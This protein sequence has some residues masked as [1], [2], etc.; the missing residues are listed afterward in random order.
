M[1]DPR[2]LLRTS[3]F[4][5]AV[6]YLL[7][8]WSSTAL[9]MGITWRITLRLV[10]EHVSETIDTEAEGLADTY[11]ARGLTGLVRVIEGRVATP[12]NAT[13]YL[14]ASP[15]FEPL[16]G[17]LS[18]W[19]VAPR[20][21]EGW[22]S[23]MLEDSRLPDSG[24]I[25]AKARSFLLAGGFHL[26]VGRDIREGDIFARRLAEGMAWALGISVALGLVGAVLLA[27]RALKRV[28]KISRTASR[29]V[30]GDLSARMPQNGSGDELDRLV[31]AVNVMLDRLEALMQGL[32]RLSHNIA[33]ELK[34]PLSRLSNRVEEA[35]R[36]ETDD[37]ATLR[38]ALEGVSAEAAQM[39]DLFR[40]LL[41]IAEAEAGLLRTTGSVDLRQLL[42]DLVELY[43]PAAE[44]EGLML[45]AALGDGPVVVEGHAQLLSRAFANLLD[46]ALKYT[47]EGGLVLV[48][49]EKL[50]EGWQVSVSDTGPGV[51][52]ADRTRVVEPFERGEHPDEISGTG[53]G[54]ALVRAVAR[55]HRAEF[56]LTDGDGTGTSPGLKAAIT[57]NHTI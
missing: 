2:A 38:A 11:R 32:T 21:G 23:F 16:A 40:A 6:L 12:S 5:I 55:A 48:R 36:Q 56:G 25:P 45:K 8:F 26:L 31:G 43:E 20:A 37:P 10:A 24:H 50:P 34:T 57:F 3:S 44:E 13:L 29:I 1:P 39:L 28:E 9:L 4:R 27:R 22:I 47:P 49:L 46:N 14:L 7:L 54:L 52:E 17:N 53:L 19:P 18:H 42:S 35:L 33:H 30:E 15:T 51:G 41:D